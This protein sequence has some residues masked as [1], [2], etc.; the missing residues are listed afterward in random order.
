MHCESLTTRWVTD[1]F[2]DGF[3]PMRDVTPMVSSLNAGGESNSFSGSAGDVVSEPDSL[4]SLDAS[5]SLSS[6]VVAGCRLWWKR[7]AQ[8]GYKGLYIFNRI[9]Q[10]PDVC[11]DVR[12]SE[13]TA[14]R[15]LLQELPYDADPDSDAA[16]FCAK[17]IYSVAAGV[18]HYYTYAEGRSPLVQRMARRGIFDGHAR[19]VIAIS[20][21]LHEV[22]AWLTLM[23]GN[24]DTAVG[25]DVNAEEQAEVLRLACDMWKAAQVVVAHGP[26]A[27][28]LVERLL[29]VPKA[30]KS[31]APHSPAAHR[32]NPSPAPSPSSHMAPV[33][34]TGVPATPSPTSGFSFGNVAAVS[35]TPVKEAARP[36]VP[37][38]E[39]ILLATQAMALWTRTEGVCSWLLRADEDGDDAA[40]VFEGRKFLGDV[41]EGIGSDQSY[42]L[43]RILQLCDCALDRND[44]KLCVAAACLLGNLLACPSCKNVLEAVRD[45]VRRILIAN[46]SAFPNSP[47][48]M[49][50][51]ARALCYFFE[52]HL[53]ESSASDA[54]VPDES[55]ASGTKKPEGGE[56]RKLS[57]HQWQ[58][59]TMIHKAS[60]FRRE[61][62]EEPIGDGGEEKKRASG[63][64][65]A[66]SLTATG[67]QGSGRQGSGDGQSMALAAQRAREA[68]GTGSQEDGS[69]PSSPQ[70]SRESSTAFLSRESSSM[71]WMA[72][73]SDLDAND[74]VRGMIALFDLAKGSDA[75]QL[76]WVA[77]GLRAC[78]SLMRSGYCESQSWVEA[79]LSERR[80]TL[81]L[82]LVTH[83]SPLVNANG[84]QCL[85]FLAEQSGK[86][87]KRAIYLSGVMYSVVERGMR[88]LPCVTAVAAHVVAL[89]AQD[90]ANVDNMLEESNPTFK[91]ILHLISLGCNVSLSD[92]SFKFV[93]FR[94][95]AG[96]VP[97]QDGKSG[98][99]R[100]RLTGMTHDALVA[101]I[102][103]TLANITA[104]GQSEGYFV[105]HT[106]DEFSY[107]V[108]PSTRCEG[109]GGGAGCEVEPV[110]IDDEDSGIKGDI[111]QVGGGGQS[112][113]YHVRCR[114]AASVFPQVQFTAGEGR[115]DTKARLL[116][117]GANGAAIYLT[118][119]ELDVSP[120]ERDDI[121][122]ANA[123][124]LGLLALVHIAQNTVSE[125]HLK[126]LVK[127]GAVELLVKLARCQPPLDAERLS[128]VSHA[129]LEIVKVASKVLMRGHGG[130]LTGYQLEELRVVNRILLS[131]RDGSTQNDAA[132]TL[133]FLN[134][135]DDFLAECEN[136][137]TPPFGPPSRETSGIGSA[138]SDGSCGHL[139]RAGGENQSPSGGGGG[140]GNRV[141][142]T[143]NSPS[144]LSGSYN[145]REGAGGGAASCGQ[146]FNSRGGA[147][148]CGQSFNSHNSDSLNHSNAA[149]RES[150]DLPSIR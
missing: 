104:Q 28:S 111:V 78:F 147:A 142:G 8:W 116:S 119:Q 24:S 41:E 30:V 136:P 31:Q 150:R 87:A 130:C 124:H 84:L 22:S 134:N 60:S 89:L 108:G 2:Y 123:G 34:S 15:M 7:H 88:S 59:A 3:L 94:Q 25:V 26:A 117:W 19:R 5:G 52:P 93:G 54:N 21:R 122:M 110:R 121:L 6:E 13:T 129:L 148:S 128:C 95:D 17:A 106:D 79:A 46:V 51:T 145:D 99:A 48:I 91:F 138:N 65:G 115:V 20:Y 45:E 33:W 126:R 82:K 40:P 90:A 29:R 4:T 69:D 14:F 72:S 149:T 97:A 127:A 61:G 47:E 66:R 77:R 144:S 56:K 85:A 23:E 139:G 141:W 86:S 43:N 10:Y 50:M 73:K 62:R 80:P 12:V 100:S 55:E 109:L 135:I 27:R 101:H 58:G 71:S 75:C 18:V 9:R 118:A 133:V 96:S 64:T 53:E 114:E 39:S 35:P 42:M 76:A 131:S 1:R 105:L 125:V 112:A 102:K 103:Q 36:E 137:G 83:F 16:L 37:V 49:R 113:V 98:E 92:A 67:R 140:G 107:T 132:A 44:S 68:V 81:L 38:S 143:D 146:S 74:E 32:Q 63:R 57:R 70:L 11:E 120:W